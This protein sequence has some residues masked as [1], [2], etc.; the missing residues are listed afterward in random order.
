MS[1]SIQFD[2][3][4]RMRYHPDFHDKHRQPWTTVD[5]TFLVNNYETLGAEECSLHLGR[6]I[7]TIY[8]RV[9]YLR[10]KG[11][12]STPTKQKSFQRQIRRSLC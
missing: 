8:D 9:H 6:T 12:M 3:H 7:G 11:V 1:S 2:A 10:S 4:G 5:Q